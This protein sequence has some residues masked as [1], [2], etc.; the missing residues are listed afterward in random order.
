MVRLFFMI[1]LLFGMCAKWLDNP[2][3]YDLQPDDMDTTLASGKYLDFYLDADSNLIMAWGSG[4]NGRV[5]A[6]KYDKWPMPMSAPWYE[7]E[8]DNYI[9]LRESCGC[10]CWTLTLLPLQKNDSIITLEEDFIRDTKRGYVFG[11]RC[12]NEDSADFCL[13]DVSHRRHHLI[14]L[15]GLREDVDITAVL[16]T[17]F[18]TNDGVYIR[19][20]RT[21]MYEEADTL[22]GF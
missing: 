4:A 22:I 10:P 12:M 13:Y 7:C 6:F 18:F 9:G 2:H 14:T 11:N 3:Q 8:F 1:S 21:P 19:W 20:K 17:C 16:D 15:P 5:G